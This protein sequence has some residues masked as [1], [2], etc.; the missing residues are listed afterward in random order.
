MFEG[1]TGKFTIEMEDRL[2]RVCEE[3]TYRDHSF[4]VGLDACSSSNVPSRLSELST[5]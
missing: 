5:S 1:I 3:T 2:F 4:L